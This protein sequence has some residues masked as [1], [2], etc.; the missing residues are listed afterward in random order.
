[1]I[2][3]FQAFFTL[4]KKGKEVTNPIFWKNLQ[5][6]GNSLAGLIS[7]I[8]VIA[9]GFGYDLHLTPEIISSAGAGIAA[10][11]GIGNAILVVITSKK[12]GT[13]SGH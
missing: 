12:V 10:L 7:A 1:M 13:G 11:Y 6:A 8:V 9:G 4:F 2:K 3:E 5:T